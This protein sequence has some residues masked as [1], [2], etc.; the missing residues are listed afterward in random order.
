MPATAMPATWTWN[1]YIENLLSK[2]VLISSAGE[3][4]VPLEGRALWK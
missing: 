2:E 4:P 1:T 3:G